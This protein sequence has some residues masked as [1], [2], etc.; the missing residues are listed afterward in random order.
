MSGEAAKF[1]ERRECLHSRSVINFRDCAAGSDFR[2]F[3]GNRLRPGGGAVIG[4]GVAEGDGA[5]LQ[6]F[7]KEGIY[8]QF[9]TESTKYPQSSSVSDAEH[10]LRGSDRGNAKRCHGAD[11]SYL[12]KAGC[13]YVF[14]SEVIFAVVF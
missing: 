8:L 9:F 7:L 5:F 14:E 12:D 2:L 13:R 6:L 11:I 1:M 10:R 3:A 4:V